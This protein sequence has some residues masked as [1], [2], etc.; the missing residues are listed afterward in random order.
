MLDGTGGGGWCGMPICGGIV[1]AAPTC[2]FDIIIMWG[3][4]PGNDVEDA[5]MLVGGALV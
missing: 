3:D 4:G 1:V 5:A 2:G